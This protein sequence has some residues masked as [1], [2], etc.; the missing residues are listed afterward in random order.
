MS[1]RTKYFSYNGLSHFQNQNQNQNQDQKTDQI[2]RLFTDTARPVEFRIRVNKRC[3]AAVREAFNAL[4]LVLEPGFEYRP[5]KGT[6]GT[7]NYDKRAKNQAKAR[8]YFFTTI[9]K[10]DPASVVI[11]DP[12]VSISTKGILIEGLSQNGQD[13]GSVFIPSSSYTLLEGANVVYGTSTIEVGPDLLDGLLQISSKQNLEIHFGSQFEEPNKDVET[14]FGT[15]KKDFVYDANW[16]REILQFLASSSL[17]KNIKVRLKRID[18]YNVLRHLRLNKAEKGEDESLRFILINGLEPQ[19][20]LEPWGFNITSPVGKYQGERSASVNFYDRDKL[21]RLEPLLPFIDYVDVSIMGEALPAFWTLNS[22]EVIYTYATLGYKMSNWARGLY[23]DQVLRRDTEN[24]ETYDQVMASLQTKSQA[25]FEE[26]MQSTGLE[27][28]EISVAVIRGIQLG[29]VAPNA[30]VNGFQYRDLFMET[31]PS[32]LVYGAARD[33]GYKEES[34]AYEIVSQNRV[35]L[36]GKITVSPTG[37]VDFARL[38][39]N[40]KKVIKFNNRGEK[41]EETELEYSTEPVEVSQKKF[42]F[43]KVDP[44]FYPKLQLN[45]LGATRK[46]GCG[47]AYMEVK[48]DGSPICSHIQALWIYYCRTY[49]LSDSTEVKALDQRILLKL[50]EDGKNYVHRLRIRSR[51]FIDESGT[52]DQLNSGVPKRR[53]R[54]F[55]READAYQAFLDRISEL[56]QQNF[57]NAG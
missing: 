29:V 40:S 42:S 30:G 32:S 9:K 56:E 14:Y 49:L 51:R 12:T 31:S 47:C 11:M 50:T 52:L 25:N 13:M 27:K 3:V 23:R 48:K 54:M 44:I 18:L 8:N 38:I 53:V 2:L 57:T 15:V 21:K 7:I 20:Q 55:Q 45:V 41:R 17:E 22:K 35:N 28:S 24:P 43:Q 46:P 34:R 37:E 6:T 26:L 5:S 4:M 19:I 36:K 10:N 39:V 16:K 1:E 33:S